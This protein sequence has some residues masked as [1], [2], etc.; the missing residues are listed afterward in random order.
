MSQ[1][2]ITVIELLVAALIILTLAVIIMPSVFPVS[3]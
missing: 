1:H 2:R 3:R